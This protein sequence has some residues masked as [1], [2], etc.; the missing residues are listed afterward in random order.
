MFSLEILGCKSKFDQTKV[1][2]L[3]FVNANVKL[4]AFVK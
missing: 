4:T 1:I 2:F 3:E